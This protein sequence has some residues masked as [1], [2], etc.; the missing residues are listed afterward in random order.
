MV[1]TGATVL[2]GCNLDAGTIVHDAGIW[3]L[4]VKRSPRSCRIGVADAGKV[5]GADVAAGAIGDVNHGVRKG[6]DGYFGGLVNTRV[7]S[8]A[9]DGLGVGGADADHRFVAFG[10]AAWV[11]SGHLI[12]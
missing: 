11:G 6:T 8:T 12:R 9:F 10:V 7:L 5:G 2:P 4:V 3:A 1:M